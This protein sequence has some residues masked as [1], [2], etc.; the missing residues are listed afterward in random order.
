M[1]TYQRG[2][3]SVSGAFGLSQS[4]RGEA[5]GERATA[6]DA[7]GNVAAVSHF[8]KTQNVDQV[9]VLDTTST[10]PGYGATLTV[11]GGKWAGTYY[12]DKIST[13]ETNTGYETMNLA[14]VRF[15]S[16]TLPS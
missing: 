5:G 8:N 3:V 15:V 13:E 11:T 10:P 16:N 6:A 2:V 12:A 4:F 1:P 14:G 7:T 9:V